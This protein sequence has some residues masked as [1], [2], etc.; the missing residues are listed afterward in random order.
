LGEGA[1]KQTG[2]DCTGQDE[3]ADTV[4]ALHETLTW[5]KQAEQ[6]GWSDK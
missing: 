1:V 3:Q 5:S 2:A 6:P 4:D